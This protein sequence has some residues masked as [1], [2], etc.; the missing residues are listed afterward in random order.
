MDGMRLMLPLLKGMEIEPQLT[1]LLLS[2]VVL[3]KH[4]QEE[5]VRVVEGTEVI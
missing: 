3:L 2:K 5:P 1:E 4:E